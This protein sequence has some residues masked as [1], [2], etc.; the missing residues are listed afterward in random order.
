VS[1]SSG[2]TLVYP[3][4]GAKVRCAANKAYALAV[5]SLD[6]PEALKVLF[7]TNDPETFRNRA[8]RET[9]RLGRPVLAFRLRDGLF[10]GTYRPDGS[11]V[12]A[13]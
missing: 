8:L 4:T 9:R 3:P 7:R 1:R 6:K 5:V 10:I 13:R 12:G 11:A 2:A